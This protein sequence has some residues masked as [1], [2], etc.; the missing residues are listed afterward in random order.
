M[1]SDDDVR[2]KTGSTHGMIE[3]IDRT[4][5]TNDPVRWF[6]G[7]THGKSSTGTDRSDPDA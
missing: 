2:Q 5:D 3:Q 4:Q 6:S 1:N 7:E